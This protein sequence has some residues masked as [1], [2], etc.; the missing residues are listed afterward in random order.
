M[1]SI[2][3]EELRMRRLNKTIEWSQ[4]A[5]NARSLLESAIE[6]YQNKKQQKSK[7][8][9]QWKIAAEQ[10]QQV[11]DA[12]IAEDKVV[13]KQFKVITTLLIDWLTPS[14]LTLKSHSTLEL[15]MLNFF[16]NFIREELKDQKQL[17]NL[18]L[19]WNYQLE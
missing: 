16:S 4:Q 10:K 13:E 6:E 7:Q 8:I 9:N 17:S 11:V 18:M 15:R 5:G 14:R 19:N 1:A 3:Q 2:H 12:I